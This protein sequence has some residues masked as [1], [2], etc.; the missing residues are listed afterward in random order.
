MPRRSTADVGTRRRL[1]HRVGHPRPDAR[2]R[3]TET[4]PRL[5]GHMLRIPASVGARSR[6]LT[7]DEDPGDTELPVAAF[8][9]WAGPFRS[10]AAAA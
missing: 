10:P 4:R 5:R 8:S 2:F 7:I 1:P 3:C 6:L 9:L